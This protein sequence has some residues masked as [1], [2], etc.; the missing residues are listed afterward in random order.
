MR[1]VTML[2][3]TFAAV[4]GGGGPAGGPEPTAAG[5]RLGEEAVGPA[6]VIES[7]HDQSEIDGLLG[8][9]ARAVNGGDP[10]G[11]EAVVSPA[12]QWFSITEPGSHEV[13]YGQREIVAH[14]LAMHASG[15][16]FVTAPTTQQ[17]TLRGWD[18]AGHFGLAAFTFERDGREI[19]LF[20]KGALY[21][22]GTARGVEV[23][24]LGVSSESVG[25][26]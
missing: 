8:S 21:C 11:I 9:F 14:L 25:P 10:A 18:G 13:A 22:G 1:V 20:G 12:A 7:C 24:S 3:L 6:A 15:D 2:A 16:R 4:A 5:T 19:R 26:T 17:I 23:L